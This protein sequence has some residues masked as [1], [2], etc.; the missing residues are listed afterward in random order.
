MKT[1]KTIAFILLAAVTISSAFSQNQY[2]YNESAP[3]NFKKAE[4]PQMMAPS[5]KGGNEALADFML[6]NLQYPEL[7]KRQGVEGTVILAYTI[8]KN[9]EIKNIEVAQSVNKE[10]DSEAVRLAEKM[11][12]WTPAMQDGAARD[13]KY[14]LPVKFELIF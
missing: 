13:I 1:L 12:R 2:A 8:T 14:Q 3:E 5:F 4:S 10:L 7:A 11:P 6:A 9:G